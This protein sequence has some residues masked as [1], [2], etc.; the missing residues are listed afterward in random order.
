MNRNDLKQLSLIRL[1]EARVLLKNKNY[2][3]AYYLCG[4]VIECGLKACISGK[5]KRFDFPDKKTVIE[6]YTHDLSSLVKTAGLSLELDKEVRDNAAFATN[7]NIVKD[8]AETSRYEKHSKK[9][10]HDLFYA[11]ADVKQGVLRWLKQRW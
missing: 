8:W 1:K 4:Y 2:E 6:S 5:T 10:A 9:E 11:V 7:W 3:G